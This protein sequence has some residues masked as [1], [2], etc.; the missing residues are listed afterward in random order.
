MVRLLAWGMFVVVAD[1]RLNNFDVLPD[2][3]GWAMVLV[4]LT[5]LGPLGRDLRRAT[6]TAALGL[7]VSAVQLSLFF[8]EEPLPAATAWVQAFAAAYWWLTVWWVLLGLAEL[9]LAAHEPR[10]VQ[11]ALAG[12]RLAVVVVGLGA[13]QVLGRVV[14]AVLDTGLGRTVGVDGFIG[15]AAHAVLLAAALAACLQVL[16]DA[17]SGIATRVP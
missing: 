10:H 6:W 3:A 2:V 17:R 5:D 9:G 7:L 14:V 8:S 13:V 15:S 16:A 1:P 11:R 4:A 12:R